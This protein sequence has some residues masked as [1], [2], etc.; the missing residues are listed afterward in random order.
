MLHFRKNPLPDELLFKIA[1]LHDLLLFLPK[2]KE[3]PTFKKFY[4]SY[5]L[6]KIC[7]KKVQKCYFN[8]IEVYVLR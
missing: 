2:K 1:G 4:F 8:L 3:P 7:M 5:F 6:L